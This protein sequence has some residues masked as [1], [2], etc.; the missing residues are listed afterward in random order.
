[1]Q[2]W[3]AACAVNRGI[4]CGILSGIMHM[5]PGWWLVAALTCRAAHCAA[6]AAVALCGR[7][8]ASG[9]PPRPR[10]PGPAQ[11]IPLSLSKLMRAG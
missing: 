10:L 5:F 6:A 4:M 3:Q 2:V 9:T 8:S 11:M 1:M 7:G